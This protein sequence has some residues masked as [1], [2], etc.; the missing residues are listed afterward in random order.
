MNKSNQICDCLQHGRW[1]HMFFDSKRNLKKKQKKTNNSFDYDY[2]FK[3]IKSLVHNLYSKSL[4]R[5]V[6]EEGTHLAAML[7]LPIFLY[8]TRTP[9]SIHI[10]FFPLHS[11]PSTRKTFHTTEATKVSLPPLPA[12]TTCSFRVD[13][14]SALLLRL[15][16]ITGTHSRAAA[17]KDLIIRWAALY[18]ESIVRV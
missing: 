6:D 11:F 14:R 18:R 9:P 4:A 12:T 15:Y 7:Y 10:S 3:M 1:R 8:L 13:G 2:L 17:S 16:I 5:M